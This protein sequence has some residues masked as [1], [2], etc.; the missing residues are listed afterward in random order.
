MRHSKSSVV[1][2]ALS[3]PNRICPVL[4]PGAVVEGSL[5]R[6]R[7]GREEV[8]VQ[9]PAPFLRKIHQWCREDCTLADLAV[10]SQDVWG[11]DRFTAFVQDLLEAGVMVDAA[12]WL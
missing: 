4:R 1:S 7:V 2:D 5:L 10:R 6:A 8:R 9:A 12:T 3:D 11:D